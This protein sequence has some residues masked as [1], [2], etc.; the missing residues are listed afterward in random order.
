M[1][2]LLLTLTLLT[3]CVAVVA[4]RPAAPYCFFWQDV[5][6]RVYKTCRQTRRSCVYSEVRLVDSKPWVEVIHSCHYAL[7]EK[8]K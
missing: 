7:K 3:G 5:D 1:R 6:G 4:P 2:Y 8:S